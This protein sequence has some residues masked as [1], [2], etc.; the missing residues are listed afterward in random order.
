MTNSA[1]KTIIVNRN[2]MLK[3]DSAMFKNDSIIIKRLQ[4]KVVLKQMV[5][6]YDSTLI[7]QLIDTIPKVYKQGRKQG[8]KEGFIGGVL[9]TESANVGAKLIK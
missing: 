3:K 2:D 6:V 8:R 9:L 1:N 5:R 4:N 7:V